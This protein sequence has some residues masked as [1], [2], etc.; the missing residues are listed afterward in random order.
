MA[1]VSVTTSADGQTQPS[2]AESLR[3]SAYSSDKN[4]KVAL[5]SSTEKQVDQPNH[6]NPIQVDGNC[7]VIFF[8]FRKYLFASDTH[9]VFANAKSV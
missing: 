8:F 4:E 5:S 3:K 9:D 7:F 2:A 1:Q 6:G